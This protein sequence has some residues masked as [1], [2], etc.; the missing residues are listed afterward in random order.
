MPYTVYD[1]T[2]E[3]KRTFLQKVRMLPNQLRVLFNDKASADFELQ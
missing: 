3:R 2:T 1:T